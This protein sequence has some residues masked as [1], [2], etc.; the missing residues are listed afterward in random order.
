VYLVQ[1]GLTI[2]DVESLMKRTNLNG[3][4]VVVS[5]ESQYLLGYILKRDIQMAL[6]QYRK[7]GIVNDNTRVRFSRPLHANKHEDCINLFKLV[8]L[9]CVF[10]IIAKIFLS[11]LVKF[12]SKKAPICVT[13]QTGM[14]VV[15]DL[16]RKMGVSIVLVTHYG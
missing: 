12:V 1:E 3:Y 6:G 8:D 14:E 13:D 5:A 2:V 15:I 7:S 11:S 4:P 16:F 10:L 9:V